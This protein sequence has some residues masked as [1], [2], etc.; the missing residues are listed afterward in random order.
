MGEKKAIAILG[1]NRDFRREHRI[2]NEIEVFAPEYTIDGFGGEAV[3]GVEHFWHVERPHQLVRKIVVLLGALVPV[4]RIKFESRFYERYAN[5]IRCKG[6]RFVIAHHVDDALIASYSGVPFLFHSHEYLPRQFDGSWVFRFTEMRYR[7]VAI[8]RILSK[9]V[10]TIVEGNRVAQEYSS[11]YDI[12]LERF[13]TMPS[14][15]RYHQLQPSRSTEGGKINLVHHGLL[16]P[17][18]G[19]ALLI[20]IVEALGDGYTLTLMGPGPPHYIAKL[21][22]R[23][24]LLGNVFVREPV[25]YEEIVSEINSYDLGLIVFGSPHY[26]HRYMTVPNKFWECLQARVPVL[27]SPGSA[28]ADYIHQYECGVVGESQSLEG[29]V[30][31]IR[32]LSRVAIIAMK[33]RCNSLAWSHSRDSWLV[34]YRESVSR[35]VDESQ[36]G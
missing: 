24:A 28:M 27:V 4:F 25:S 34:S 13:A 31:A 29:F 15:P 17:E 32:S 14:M 30:S 21:R 36:S 8:Q 9:A 26:H 10:L 7:H 19:I 12:P 35:A 22:H 16:V 18:R 3:G 33:D 5:L 20:D 1:F 6:Y 23:A 2:R 11:V